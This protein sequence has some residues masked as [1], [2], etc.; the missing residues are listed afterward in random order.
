MTL[1]NTLFS[2]AISIAL[3]D[4]ATLYAK[5]IANIIREANIRVNKEFYNI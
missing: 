5:Y 1:I 3:S 2:I 4:K